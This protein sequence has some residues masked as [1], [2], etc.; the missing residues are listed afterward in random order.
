VFSS[1]E[2][3]DSWKRVR[4]P[5][6]KINLVIPELL[7]ELEK[8]G[9]KPP[10]LDT[11]FP[12]VLSAGERRSYTANTIYRNPGWRKKK[13]RDAALRVNPA[14]AAALGLED[15]DRGRVTT[16]RGFAEA[17]VE[18]SDMMQPGHISLPN[19]L[20]LD[21]DPGDGAILRAGV[22]PNELTASEDRDFL[23]GTPWHK[24]VPARVERAP[25]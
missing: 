13:G 19:G 16:R 22:S 14:D 3:G 17:A 4:T 10:T 12:F 21:Y 25:A 8:L 24:H 5:G 18:I 20:G 1:E 15:G 11:E 23:A 6:G 2:Y 9:G 7:A